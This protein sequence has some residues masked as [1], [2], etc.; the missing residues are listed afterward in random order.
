MNYY[1]ENDMAGA[2][3]PP[4]LT[5]ALAVLFMGI[6]TFLAS[7]VLA[8][9]NTNAVQSSDIKH[10]SK[11]MD[12]LGVAMKESSKESRELRLVLAKVIDVGRK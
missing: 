7:Q 12:S 8:N 5:T 4:W 11:A 2:K 3:Y 6:V 10:L 1:D 9:S